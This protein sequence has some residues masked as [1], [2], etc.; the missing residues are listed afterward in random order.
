MEQYSCIWVL[1][2]TWFG[3]LITFGNLGYWKFCSKMCAY[4]WLKQEIAKEIKEKQE[5]ERQKRQT[6]LNSKIS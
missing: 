2:K 1:G 4:E 3:S 5:N 6:T